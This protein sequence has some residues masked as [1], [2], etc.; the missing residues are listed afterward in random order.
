V[1]SVDDGGVSHSRPPLSRES[2]PIVRRSHARV[3][4]IGLIVPTVASFDHPMYVT[5]LTRAQT[6]TPCASVGVC[7]GGMPDERGIEGL[8]TY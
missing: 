2:R 5:S 4:L 1:P 7:I 6:P 8:D 3:Y